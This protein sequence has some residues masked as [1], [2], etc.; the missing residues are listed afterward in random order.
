MNLKILR[1]KLTYYSEN[2]KVE[3]MLKKGEFYMS[4][5]SNLKKAIVEALADKQEHDIQFI[6]F[7]LGN[8]KNL[9]YD[10]DYTKNH[11]AGALRSLTEKGDIC[12]VKRGVYRIAEK[13]FSM[14][15]DEGQ[16]INSNNKMNFAEYKSEISKTLYGSYIKL[17][18]YMKEINLLD[19]EDEDFLYA[20]DL[21][22]LF[23]TL[24]DFSTK[25]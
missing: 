20:K 18:K 21:V 19:L 1:N 14:S 13:H 12:C 15:Y 11:L 25:N 8:Q 24:K 2:D 16:D 23:K 10:V 3:E 17:E 7:F 6:K 22:K 4:I 5:S 9:K